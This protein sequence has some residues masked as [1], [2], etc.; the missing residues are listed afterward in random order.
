MS[1]LKDLFKK[2]DEPVKTYADFWTWFIQHEKSFANAVRKG[3]TIERDF[4]DKLSP[5][6]EELK[7]GFFFLAGMLDENT[8]ELV[9]TPDGAVKN[10]VFAEELVAAAPV[11]PGWKFTALKPALDIANVRIDFEWLFV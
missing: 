11:I 8:A 3:N 4:F 10:I 7:D 6:L 2:K 5:K 1:F 9:I